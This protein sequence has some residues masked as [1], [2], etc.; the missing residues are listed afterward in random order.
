M[1]RGKSLNHKQKN[2]PG[3]FPQNSITE[4]HRKERIEDEE[5][6]V[7]QEAFKNRVEED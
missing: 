4:K 5:F 2:H 3:N 6:I 1:A 7:V